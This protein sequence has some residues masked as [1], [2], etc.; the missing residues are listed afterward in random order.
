MSKNDLITIGIA[1]FNAQDTIERAIASALAQDWP[2]KEIVIVDDGSSDGSVDIVKAFIADHPEAR[3]IEHA[4]NTGPA[5]VRQT[6]LDEAK[7]EFVAFFD[8]DDEGL[9]ERLSAQ[10]DRITAYEK[11]AGE[12][13]IACYASG[14]RVYPNGYELPLQ[15][16]GSQPEIPQGAGVADRL[17]FFG[18]DKRFFFGAGTPTCSLMARKSTFEAAGGFDAAFRRVEDVDF[19]IRLALAGG[20]FI[21]C[22]Q[23]L[24]IQHATDAPDKAPEKNRDAELQLVEKH[25]A[26]LRSRK[27]YIY[28]KK[29][30]LLRYY[31]FKGRYMQ[32]ALTLLELFLRY[33]VK[34]FSHF[35]STAPKRFLHERKMKRRPV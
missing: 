34:T 8:D 25:Q 28:A 27:R 3:L 12:R 29:W 1:C 18:G 24:F 10:Y 16:I 13:L 32:M 15:A 22:S 6:I 26:Y 33:P 17:L 7:G 19:A 2:R 14:K 11:Q 35:M 9:P 30:P 4:E 20:H 5:G 23:S 21:G 31:H